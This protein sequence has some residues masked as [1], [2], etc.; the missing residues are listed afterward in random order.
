MLLLYD[1]YAE[2]FLCAQISHLFYSTYK[3]ISKP[4][5]LQEQKTFHCLLHKI[6]VSYNLLKQKNLLR[7]SI[8]ENGELS[9]LTEITYYRIVRN[10]LKRNFLLLTYHF[11]YDK[12]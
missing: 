9:I 7:R 1:K 8:S 5:K 6:I 12:W 11:L 2:N 10:E 3:Y 4:I